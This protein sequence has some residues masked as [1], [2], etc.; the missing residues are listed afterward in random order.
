MGKGKGGKAKGKGKGKAKR[1]GKR[2]G[3]GRE[4]DPNRPNRFLVANYY[5]NLIRYHAYVSILM[6]FSTIQLR[7]NILHKNTPWAICT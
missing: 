4:R 1:N 7:S 3:K 5:V 6:G 2:K